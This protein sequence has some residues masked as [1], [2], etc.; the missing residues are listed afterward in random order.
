MLS[1]ITPHQISNFSFS[2]RNDGNFQSVV[3]LCVSALIPLLSPALLHGKLIFTELEERNN[4]YY[5]TIP[6]GEVWIVVNIYRDVKRRGIYIYLGLWTDPKWDSCF[7]SIYQISWIN[8][9][10]K[11]L[12]FSGHLRTASESFK[13]CHIAHCYSKMLKKRQFHWLLCRTALN[14]IRE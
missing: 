11:W 13:V 1:R 5:A 8:Y 12:L 4:K 3:C 7:S 10:E 9:R 2:S 6:E 14:I